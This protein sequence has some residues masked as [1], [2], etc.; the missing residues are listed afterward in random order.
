MN[1]WILQID[2]ITENFVSAF[3]SLSIEELHWKPN[4]QTWS[5]AQN[6]DHLIIINE[7]YYPIL[8]SLHQGTYNTPFIGKLGFMV[9]FFGNMILHA[10]KPD[11][12]KK[13]KTFPIWEPKFSEKK[14]DILDKFK[15]HQ[16]ELKNQIE[17]SKGLVEKGTVISSPANK[18]LVYKLETAFDIIV[19]HEQR[20]FEQA[21]EIFSLMKNGTTLQQ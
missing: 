11:R 3:G 10:V 20:H 4:E 16:A 18:Y 6:I 13:V 5:I 17:S 8:T 9:S 2:Q 14:G 15:R 7:T 21:K 19:T 1:N 12:K